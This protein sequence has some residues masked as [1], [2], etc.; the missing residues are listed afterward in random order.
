MTG[1][2]NGQIQIPDARRP[3]TRKILFRII[4][5]LKH[6]TLNHY[7]CHLFKSLFSLMYYACLRASEVIT[8][9]TPQH[10]ITKEQL[11]LLK[12]H[13]SYRLHLKSYKHSHTNG[14]TIYVNSTYETDCPV[15]HLDKYLQLRGTKVGPLYQI[16]GSP[17][18]RH[19]FT[20]VL[21]L[22]L[23]YINLSPKDYNTHSFRIG[24]TTDMAA[25]NVP[26]TTIQHIGRWKSTA[27][28]K[29]VRPNVITSLPR[30]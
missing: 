1:L 6:C 27:Y 9:G 29:Y 26:H 8:T 14:F 22:C 15:R 20:K 21:H 4:A 16:D 3:I 25:A 23:K 17:I 2:K 24:R 10:I 7:E 11:C 30:H 13:K 19:Q 12:D 18:T 28:L 5:A